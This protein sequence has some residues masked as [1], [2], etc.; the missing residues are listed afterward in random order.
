M[1][2]DKSLE[3][4]SLTICAN[5]VTIYRVYV[6]IYMRCIPGYMAQAT[7]AQAYIYIVIYL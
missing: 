6:S 7:H 1:K 3:G 4:K 5:H 2:K